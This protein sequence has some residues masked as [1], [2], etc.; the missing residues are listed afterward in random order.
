MFGV[1]PIMTIR[2]SVVA[3]SLVLTGVAAQ[4]QSPGVAGGVNDY[5]TAARAEYVVCLHG[6]QR[7][8]ARRR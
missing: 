8:D 4:A 5:P 3:L 1:G 6:L 2:I 7:P